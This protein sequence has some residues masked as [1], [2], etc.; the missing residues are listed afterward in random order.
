[1]KLNIRFPKGYIAHP[2]WPELEK[3]IN[4]QKESGTRRARSEANRAKALSDHLHKIGLTNVDYEAMVRMAERPFYT[5]ADMPLVD[6]HD[7]A[8]IVVPPHQIY[9]C[10]AQA[11]D[12]A[13]SSVRIASR[14]Q[15]RSLLVVQPMF[16]G[17][18]AADGIWE[19][20]AV[21][22]AGTGA[23]LSNQRAL[24]RNAYLGPFE[25]TLD[26]AFDSHVVSEAKVREFVAYAGREVGLGASRKM[27][28]GRFE[29]T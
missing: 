17:R 7:P 5:A 18:T 16:T 10:L 28:W 3:V 27:G 2:Y 6:G 9:G 25:T 12:T 21:V 8:E 19:R 1:M 29:V 14:D 11:S 13:R 23:K 22:T 24:R 20:F 26:I 4:I 15:L